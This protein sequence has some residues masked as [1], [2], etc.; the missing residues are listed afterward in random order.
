RAPRAFLSTSTAGCGGMCWGA[1]SP[2]ARTVPR[3][4]YAVSRPDGGD[5]SVE[6]AFVRGWWRGGGPRGRSRHVHRPR[7][8]LTR[9]PKGT[10]RPSD[11]QPP[12]RVDDLAV[13]AHLEVQVRPGGEAGGPHLADHLA[14]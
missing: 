10:V 7:R 11:P 5:C 1:L 6:R 14:G 13:E 3:G 4:W 8:P 12:G 2:D 9:D